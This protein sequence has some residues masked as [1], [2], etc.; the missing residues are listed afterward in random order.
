MHLRAT[1]VPV[2]LLSFPSTVLRDRV[3]QGPE[4]LRASR[5]HLQA[6]EAIPRQLCDNAGFDATDLLSRLRNK[7]AL[8]DDRGK[9]FGI[10]VNTGPFNL[11]SSLCSPRRCQMLHVHMSAPESCRSSC[12]QA[13]WPEEPAVISSR[14]HDRHI[15]FVRV[16]AIAGEDQCHHRG[17]R[18][19]LPRPVCR[20]DGE[21]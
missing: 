13:A 6:L 11:G 4:I 9:H 1:E 10:D 19:R 5:F 7:H 2:L 20:R 18:G 16:G 12:S 15:R 14:R 17:N 3:V 8:S 21:L